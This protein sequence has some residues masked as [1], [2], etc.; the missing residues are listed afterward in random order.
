MGFNSLFEVP[1]SKD[2]KPTEEDPCEH[3]DITNKYWP[4]VFYY[5]C[6]NAFAW[7]P[8]SSLYVC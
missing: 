1:I 5:V 7:L 4:C 3:T 2:H 6:A 8:L